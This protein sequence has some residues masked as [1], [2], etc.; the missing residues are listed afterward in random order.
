[1]KWGIVQKQFEYMKIKGK[2]N[3]QYASWFLLSLMVSWLFYEVDLCNLF[4]C[5]L[6]SWHAGYLNNWGREK[7]L[8]FN[9]LS[10]WCDNCHKK[11]LGSDEK[12]SVEWNKNI[13]LYNAAHLSCWKGNG[14]SKGTSRCYCFSFVDDRAIANAEIVTLTSGLRQVKRENIRWNPITC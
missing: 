3:C 9:F 14:G 12:F 1:M 4:I 5:K 7:S 11:L 2:I 8:L 13:G 10:K 6:S